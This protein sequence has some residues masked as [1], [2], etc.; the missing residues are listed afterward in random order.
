MLYLVYPWSLQDLRWKPIFNAQGPNAKWAA[1]K[2]SEEE[3]HFK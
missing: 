3:F 2:H 1:H